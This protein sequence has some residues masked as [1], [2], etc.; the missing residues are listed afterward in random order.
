MPCVQGDACLR[1]L[2]GDRVEFFVIL[3]DY[4]G[5]GGLINGDAAE[6]LNGAN[7]ENGDVTLNGEMV[8]WCY[9]RT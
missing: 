6:L 5:H 4:F 8:E 2:V 9:L 1:K 7:G 3:D